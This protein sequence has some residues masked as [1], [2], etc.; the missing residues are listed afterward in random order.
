VFVKIK[1]DDPLVALKLQVNHRLSTARPPWRGFALAAQI[2]DAS[3][4]DKRSMELFWASMLLIDIAPSSPIVTL[5]DVIVVEHAVRRRRYQEWIAWSAHSPL[6]RVD[7]D[8][9][10]SGLL[11]ERGYT[12]T[13]LAP[14]IAFPA[15]I[16]YG[17][18]H[19][20]IQLSPLR[21]RLVVALAVALRKPLAGAS[22]WLEATDA[23][24]RS[25]ARSFAAAIEE[26]DL[27]PDRKRYWLAD[28]PDGADGADGADAAEGN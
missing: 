1:P 16:L 8:G 17:V 20:W 9:S 14:E 7:D 28:T 22:E 5:A 18:E 12:L 15:S 26:S 19:G 23:R 2:P 10:A 6:G 11:D 25:G 13:E 21:G 24:A 3:A 4:E 27:S